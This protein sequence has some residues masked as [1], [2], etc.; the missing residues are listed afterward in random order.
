M[1]PSA[2]HDAL[3]D[4]LKSLCPVEITEIPTDDAGL[5]SWLQTTFKDACLLI[6]SVPL[7]DPSE[8][9]S[10]NRPRSSSAASSASEI[11]L[12]DARP[13]LTDDSTHKLQKVWGKPV[14]IAPK[15]N[16]LGTS[17]YKLAGSDSKG[18]WF[19]RRSVHEGLGFSKWKKALQAEFAETLK[20][21]SGPGEGNIRGIGGE[22]R[23]EA[24]ETTAG[25]LE[26]WDLTAQFPGP[27]TPREFVEAVCT[28][29]CARDG[30]RHFMIVS[31]PCL[32]P[33]APERSGFIRGQYQ[34]VEIIRE[35]PNA[36][37][38][39]VSKSD[40][41]LA[42]PKMTSHGRD[43][44]KTVSHGQ[45]NSHTDEGDDTNPVE[46][47]MLTR[48]DPGGSV[49]RFMVE[50]GTPGSIVADAARFLDWACGVDEEELEEASDAPL[51]Q[52]E[53]AAAD[54][55][56]PSPG[57]AAQ[58][59]LAA[60]KAAQRRPKVV[61]IRSHE[62]NG[63]LAG[64][65][66]ASEEPGDI[67]RTSTVDTSTTATTD[68]TGPS[69]GGWL[70]SVPLPNIVTGAASLITSHIPYIG[71]VGEQEKPGRRYSSSSTSS[72]NSG[73]SFTS[74]MGAHVHDTD[75]EDT[76]HRHRA[77]SGATDSTTSF[78][79][80]EEETA[81]QAGMDGFGIGQMIDALGIN[82]AT[83]VQKVDEKEEKEKSKLA[84]RKNRLADKLFKIRQKELDRSSEDKEVEERSTENI[85]KAEEKY[86]RE[87]RRQEERFRREMTKLR[88]KR[89]REE[90]KEI[91]RQAKERGRSEV[92]GVKSLLEKE[93]K[94]TQVLR[95]ERDLLRKQVLELQRENTRLAVGV[96]KLPGGNELLT[97]TR[98]RRQGDPDG[99]I[100]ERARSGS[101]LRKENRLPR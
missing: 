25:K 13:P 75:S 48:S 30:M 60:D 21:G 40:T 10:L 91:D 6:D 49:P 37:P 12:S 55:A 86:E 99:N 87:V 54:V 16:P 71:T 65:A 26:V 67:S 58:S 4:A 44:A 76:I 95:V 31:K 84:R 93:K 53:T 18:A 64:I 8:A 51:P 3:H 17:V 66:G 94:E 33:E 72:S 50:R 77:H 32:H 100:I 46:W 11:I 5:T 15:E 96:G 45:G 39:M 78:Q 2:L 56:E 19:A 9:S 52:D 85:R 22:K 7:S 23:V 43:R 27:T 68:T 88:E 57:F 61:R 92:D 74:A 38:N 24:R 59:G 1:A 98:E 41:N 14:N 28:T 101:L 82:S 69:R 34:S 36:G 20:G 80:L 79:T 29:D 63:H 47:I 81:L 73:G 83:G 89:E 35:V 62:T 90:R 70:P 97:E 42:S